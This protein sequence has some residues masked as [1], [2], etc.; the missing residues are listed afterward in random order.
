MTPSDTNAQER[1]PQAPVGKLYTP[2]HLLL[3]PHW[4]TTA[5]L[6]DLEPIRNTLDADH[7]R[8]GNQ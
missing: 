2:R 8:E 4:P 3:T 5:D 7:Y 6:I 1:D